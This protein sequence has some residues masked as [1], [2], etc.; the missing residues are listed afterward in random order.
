MENSNEHLLHIILQGQIE[1]L[2][3]L[4]Y[5]RAYTGELGNIKE[6]SYVLYADVISLLNK[7]RRSLKNLKLK[8]QKQHKSSP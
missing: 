1:V 8:T 2:E 5:T 6:K 3:Q 4:Q 7:K